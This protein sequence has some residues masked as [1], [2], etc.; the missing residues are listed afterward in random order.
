MTGFESIREYERFLRT[1]THSAGLP[2]VLVARRG[3]ALLGSVNFLA[4]EMTIRPEL[5]PW[6]AQLFVVDAERGGG[7]GGALIDAVIDHA[8]ELGFRRLHLYTSGTL[9]NYYASRGWRPIEEVEYLGR[10]RT[11]MAFDLP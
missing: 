5:S 9:P 6:L 3:A 11:I 4:S 8:A 10:A 1:S 7:V 2:T